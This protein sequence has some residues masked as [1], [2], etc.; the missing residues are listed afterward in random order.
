MSEFPCKPQRKSTSTVVEST[1]LSVDWRLRFD[2]N[3]WK[4]FR[5]TVL[6]IHKGV[7]LK[8]LLF[9]VIIS[10][11]SNAWAKW[12]ELAK[13]QNGSTYLIDPATKKGGSRPRVWIWAI[14]GQA[15]GNVRSYKSLMEADCNAGR[16]RGLTT[17]YFYDVDAN[18]ISGSD[19]QPD[20]WSYPI[21]E[22]IDEALYTY[23][24]G[25]TP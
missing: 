5:D 7:R 16:S 3:I 10:I 9:L 20:E 15:K 24:C 19:S 12:V 11:S 2:R 25:K 21:P 8:K 1:N 6:T 17:T 13:T 18:S 4:F 14:Y 23:L 22:S